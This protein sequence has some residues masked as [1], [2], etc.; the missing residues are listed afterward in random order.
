MTPEGEIFHVAS[1]YLDANDMYDEAVFAA[2]LFSELEDASNGQ[3][4]DLVAKAHADRIEEL[5]LDDRTGMFQRFQQM[6]GTPFTQSDGSGSRFQGENIFLP[7][8]QN[9]VVR[10][11]KFSQRFPLMT[12]Q[13]LEQDP[14]QLVGNGRSF[15][16]SSSSRN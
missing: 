8:I 3:R 9:Q 5:G 15:F 4:A 2:Q 12:Y 16:S 11:Q 13:Q 10:D 14:T 1:G 7:F 6:N